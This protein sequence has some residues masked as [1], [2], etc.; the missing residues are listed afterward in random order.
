MPTV[1]NFRA[2]SP[3][4]VSVGKDNWSLTVHDLGVLRVPSGRLEASDPFVNLGEGI[5]VD[6]PP[7]DY[8]VRV[9]VADVSDE[10][11]GSHLREAYLSVV[12][13][14]GEVT[15]VTAAARAGEV[16]ED[17]KYFSVP[18]DAGTVGFADA[19][20]VA[21]AMPAGDWYEDVYDNGR[22]DSWFAL[23][24]S[25]E[26]LIKGCANVVMP[27]ATAGENVVLAHSGW[28]DGYYPVLSTSDS[29]GRLL[30][31]HIDLLVV[32]EFEDQEDEADEVAGASAT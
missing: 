21:S 8:P 17:G 29:D 27:A 15:T 16:P 1:E 18:V 30:A 13:A 3:G 26:H 14:E 2:L 32:A 11:D 31:V 6:I 19:D 4:P 23:I 5:V 22:D 25:K 9:T 12:L 10:Q 20:A 24:D 28:G 7:G